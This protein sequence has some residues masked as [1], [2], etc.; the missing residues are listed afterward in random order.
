V[1]AGPGVL[2][3]LTAFY[4]A[5]GLFTA[6]RYAFFMRITSP[7][8]AAAQFTAFMAMTNVC[9][10]WAVAAIGPLAAGFGYAV[11]FATMAAISLVALPLLA[12]P[13]LAKESA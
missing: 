9:E 1:G 6:A 2:F 11:A 5:I 4:V 13:V 3:P 7:H 10:V 8:H 12:L